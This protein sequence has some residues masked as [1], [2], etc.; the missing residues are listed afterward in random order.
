MIYAK[1][2]LSMIYNCFPKQK[3]QKVLK[4]KFLISFY[5]KKEN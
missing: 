1:D 5:A 2:K 4:K 3:S